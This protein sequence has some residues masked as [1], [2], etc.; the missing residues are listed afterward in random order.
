MKPRIDD[1]IRLYGEVATIRG[2]PSDWATR[3]A[4][5]AGETAE[6][7]DAVRG[8]SGD[9]EEEF[10]DTLIALLAV[11]PL[12]GECDFDGLVERAIKKLE[13]LCTLPLR[14]HEIV[15]GPDVGG[16]ITDIFHE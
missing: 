1:L 10:G 6:L 16:L 14:S 12:V 9:P 15:A 11:M 13:S 3:Y 7:F 5:L 8:K 2:W 4:I